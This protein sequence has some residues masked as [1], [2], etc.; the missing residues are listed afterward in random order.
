MKSKR[1]QLAI[2]GLCFILILAVTA[3]MMIC[4]GRAYAASTHEEVILTLRTSKFGSQTYVTGHAIEKV[5]KNAKHPWLR[6]I[7]VEGIGGTDNALTYQKLPDEKRA[8]R[9]INVGD[10]GYMAAQR[11]SKPWFKKPITILRGGMFAWDW[12]GVLCQL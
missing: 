9:I 1:K 11:G 5:V 12:G 3:V 6:A 2:C 7:S 4:A 8:T 10:A